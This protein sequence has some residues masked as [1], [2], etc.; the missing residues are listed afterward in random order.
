MDYIVLDIEFNGRKF[1]SDLPMEVIEIGAVRLDAELRQT[2]QF[3]ALVKPVYFAKLN[4]FIQK[5]TG[6]PQEGIDAAAGFPAVIKDFLDWL[7]PSERFLIITWG[8]EDMKRIVF[9]TRMHGLDD[10]Y[11]LGVNYYDLLKGYI[12]Y[13]GVMNDV[14]VENALADLGL[15]GEDNQAHRALEDARMTSEIFRAVFGSLDFSRIQQYVDVYSNAKERKLV[16]NA[17]R[18]IAA[19]KVTPTW[20]LIV[21]HVLAGK[22]ATDDA[23]KMAEL[24]AV[25]E[26]EMAKPQRKPRPA[27]SPPKAAAADL[28]KEPSKESSTDPSTNSSSDTSSNAAASP[29]TNSAALS[30]MNPANADNGAQAPND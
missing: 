25:F 7:G 8:G 15:G 20:P 23:R 12:R 27:S 5:K 14:S 17:I 24:E 3:T 9:D 19:Q 11:W 10:A 26:A 21:E 29:S 18:I 28:S 22:I 6:I 1:A 16:K 2:S 13:K 30:S 4:D